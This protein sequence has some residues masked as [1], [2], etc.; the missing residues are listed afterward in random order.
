MGECMLTLVIPWCVW[1]VEC[2]L[3]F[4]RVC[5]DWSVLSL[6]MV[7]P[8]GCMYVDFGNPMVCMDG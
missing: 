1:M 5:L 7:C 6:V 3:T 2:V 8:D 4:V